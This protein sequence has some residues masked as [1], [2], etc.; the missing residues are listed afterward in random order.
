MDS[1]RGTVDQDIFRKHCL[2]PYPTLEELPPDVRDKL[3]I[4]PF[5]RNI[6]Y[7]IARSHGL[8][9][10][11]LGLIATVLKAKYEWDVN[12][13]VAE[14]YEMSQDKIDHIAC[15]SERVLDNTQ[16]PWTARD[17]TVLRLVD[18]QLA[19]YTNQPSTILDAV[20]VLGPD[21]VVEVLIVIG[22]YA[23]LARLINGLKIDDDLEI[24]NLKERIRGAI[25][26]T[27]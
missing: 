26:E 23:L 4:L 19:T 8:A 20:D 10:H 21:L 3:N 9:P 22:L 6:L 14:I 13:P 17:R 7:T 25:T 11:L 12:I 1:T 2:V 27:R 5:R 18:E 16:G 15:S 24:P